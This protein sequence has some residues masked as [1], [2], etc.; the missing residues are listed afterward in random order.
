V[1][2]FQ[3]LASHVLF[4]QAQLRPPPVRLGRRGEGQRALW[5]QGISGDLPI[6]AVMIAH[7]RDIEIVREILSAHAF[8]SL[9]GLKTD[10]VL[11][12]EEVGATTTP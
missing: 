6:V 7:L 3:Q 5:R 1:Q 9:R 2:T 10:L 4:P 8:W 11:V 12:S